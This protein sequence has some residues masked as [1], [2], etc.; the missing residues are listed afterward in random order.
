MSTTTT[1]VDNGVD[2]EFL[3]GAREA[4]TAEPEGAKF[5]VAGHQHLGARHPQPDA[6]CRASSASARSRTRPVRF[7]FD[8]D[9]P[10]LFS[11]ENNGAT[12]VEIVLVGLASCLTGGLAAV[13]QN[14]EIQLRSVQRHDRGRHGRARHPR[15]RLRRAQRLQQH[16]GHLH[17]RCRRLAGGHRGAGGPVAEALGRL[18]PHHQPHQR[19][20]RGRWIEVACE[21]GG[22]G[23]S[24][25]AR[26]RRA[27]MGIVDDDIVAV[28]EATD[29]V[30]VITKYTQLRRSGQRW[31]GL[32]PF[33]AEKTPSF[34]VNQELGLYRCWGCQ[35][36]GDVITFV[37][38][39]E[40]LDFVGAVELL[41]GWAGITL[42]YSDKGEG[43]SRKRRARLVRGRRAG[44]RLVPRAA[45][46]GARRRGGPQVPARA[47]PQRRR[48]ARVPHRLGARRV[49]ARS[50]RR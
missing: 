27:A 22:A 14:R 15:D 43:E 39:V 2:V 28:R 38:E 29:I 25:P 18:R 46:V 44:G 30:A 35:V 41:A 23:T 20:R 50:C 16:Q 48:G 31:V 4:L 19:H 34:S 9:H 37:R 10:E 45:A 21:L 7:Q 33:H 17:H 26:Y 5:T 40:H 8:A 6:P 42:R 49:A 11:A 24:H 32:C 13:A 3:L 1:P 47:R 36:R 12:P